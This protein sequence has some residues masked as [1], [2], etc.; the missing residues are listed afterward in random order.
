MPQSLISVQRAEEASADDN[1]VKLWCDLLLLHFEKAGITSRSLQAVIGLKWR[2]VKKRLKSGS[3]NYDEVN[4]LLRHCEIDSWRA[5]IAVE[6]LKRPQAYFE[7]E[8]VWAADYTQRI[9]RTIIE[10]LHIIDGD[11]IPIRRGLESQAAK[12]VDE[13]F[14]Y[15]RRF[16]D[17]VA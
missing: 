11:F 3:V 4:V 8:I 7:A 16:Q 15:Q 13:L 1:G 12:L 2:T 5:S 17:F 6:E 9:L 10:R 14:A